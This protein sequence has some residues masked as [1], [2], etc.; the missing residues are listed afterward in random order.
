MDLPAL[1]P[2]SFFVAAILLAIIPSPGIAYVVARTVSGG[3]AEGIASI[4][5]AAVGGLVHVLAGAL[6]LSLLIAKSAI[7]FAAVK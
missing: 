7:A 4:L 6:G 3:K 2:F 1:P 5:G